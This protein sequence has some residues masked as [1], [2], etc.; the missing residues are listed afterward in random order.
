M[1]E[2]WD[3]RYTENSNVYGEQRNAFFKS[4]IDQHEPG[5][6]LM[7]AEGEGRNGLYAAAKGW[8]VDAFDFS[9][10]ARDRTV[11]AA[12]ERHLPIQYELMDIDSFTAGKQYDA[13]GL[14]YVH[15]PPLLR[16]SFHQEIYQSI[17][18]GGF[19]VLE[20]Y[21]KEQIHFNSGGPKDPAMLYDAPS[22]CHDFPFLHLISCE[23]KE[24]E[25]DE[26]PFHQGKAAVLRMIG[27]RL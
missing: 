10:V 17:K 1:K 9:A 15:L 26:G 2:F 23:Q 14:I 24:L 19:L 25:L 13:V 27:Q 3:N 7:P 4:F 22:L 6:I 8:K 12:R 21:A 5:T 20:A 11:A 16:Q 18:P